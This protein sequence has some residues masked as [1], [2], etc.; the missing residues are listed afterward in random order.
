[1]LSEAPRMLNSLKVLQVKIINKPIKGKETDED[2]NCTL[3]KIW[4]IKNHFK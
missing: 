2:M 1:M 3:S 4:C